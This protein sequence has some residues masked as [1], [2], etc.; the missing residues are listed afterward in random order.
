MRRRTM[1]GGLVG[2][3]RAGRLV[4]AQPAVDAPARLDSS[5]PGR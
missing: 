4:R 2:L 5:R 3:L 1:V